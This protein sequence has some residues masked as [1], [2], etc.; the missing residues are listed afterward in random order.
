MARTR[1]KDRSAIEAFYRRDPWLHLYELGDLDD[2]FWP[3]TEWPALLE[4]EGGRG[5][6][7]ARDDGPRDGEQEA[8]EAIR[9]LAL[10]Y[11]GGPLPILLA[12]GRAVEEAS[13]RR[14]IEDLA[15]S[16]PARFYAHL[17][18]AL[19]DVFRGGRQIEEHGLHLKMG[20]MQPDRERL[21][22]AVRPSRGE[23]RWLRPDD[24]EEVL[25][26]YR[27]AYP[28]S[29]FE[30]RMLETGQYA[31]ITVDGRLATVA[32]VHV[33]APSMR[34]ACL[35]NIA[36]HPECRGLGLATAA[37]AALC[38]SLLE[39]VESIGLNVKAGNEPAISCYRRLGFE[40]VAEYREY[41]IGGTGGTG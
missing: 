34:V 39:T 22:A 31:G 16:M 5:G 20:L 26:F 41:L 28:Q 7:D 12:L 8:A 36:T 18:G 14:L 2:F 9:A 37:T 24:R 29:W 10:L 15:P 35:G 13:I 4:E 27:E 11:R 23:V 3:H 6:D 30:P 33:Y 32:G 38:L 21:R 1:I 40:V 25:A 19:V 17:S